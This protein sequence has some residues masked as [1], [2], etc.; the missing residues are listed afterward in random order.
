MESTDHPPTGL[1]S[2]TN[3]KHLY[4]GPNT[5]QKHLLTTLPLPSSKAFIITTGSLANKTDL[6]QQVESILGDHHAGTFAKIQAHA[7]VHQLD[8]ASTIISQDGSIDTVLSIGGGSPIDSAKALSFRFHA[9]HGRFL[10]HITI[11]TTLSAAECTWFAGYT[12]ETG[13]KKRTGSVECGPSVILYDANFVLATPVW[14]FLSTGLRALDHAVE[15]MYNPFA[16]EF[17]TKRS[18]MV[19][20]EDLFT[21]LP[22]YKATPTDVEVIT[23]LQLAAFASLGMTGLNVRG[24]LGL[25]HTLGYALG[26]PYGI[27]HGMTSCMTLGHVVQFK[28]G[29]PRSAEQLTR[30][31]SAT[32]RQATGHHAEDARQVGEAILCLVRDLG[33][34]KRLSEYKVDPDQAEIITTRA[35]GLE[36][37]EEW[38]RVLDLVRE[39]F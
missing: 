8:E 26:S 23:R 1:W 15:T 19:A 34:A 31:V 11:P 35:T 17:P 9:K 3:L 20:T 24:G 33:L 39:L 21:F 5:V 30:L 22:Q 4:Y 2:M 27:P 10:H 38:E 25:S 14:L 13:L 6:V 28:S 37:G 12:D 16:S 36:S 32:G 18:C 7:P 29:D